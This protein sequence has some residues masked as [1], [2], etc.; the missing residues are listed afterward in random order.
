M[1]QT[2]AGES[3]VKTTEYREIREGKEVASHAQVWEKSTSLVYTVHMTSSPCSNIV[4]N[5]ETAI[6]VCM[7]CD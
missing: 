1:L 3:G 2:G 4:L 7:F 5:V 6:S